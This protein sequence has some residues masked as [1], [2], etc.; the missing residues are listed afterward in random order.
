MEK[1]WAVLMVHKSRDAFLQA[2][3]GILGHLVHLEPALPVISPCRRCF[4]LDNLPAFFAAPPSQ[5]LLQPLR[6]DILDPLHLVGLFLLVCHL[7]IT[8]LVRPRE[9]DTG[10]DRLVVLC[11]RLLESVWQLSGGL[12]VP[13]LALLVPVLGVVA[14]HVGDGTLDE[15]ERRLCALSHLGAFVEKVEDHVGQLEETEMVGERQEQDG[16]GG[17]EGGGRGVE[18]GGDDGGWGAGAG[19]SGSGRERW[20]GEKGKFGFGAGDGDGSVGGGGLD[21]GVDDGGVS[22]SV[23]SVGSVLGLVKYAV[24][25]QRLLHLLLP[26]PLVHAA[27]PAPSQSFEVLLHTRPPDEHHAALNLA[28]LHF[29]RVEHAGE[30][31]RHRGRRE[32]ECLAALEEDGGVQLAGDGAVQRRRRQRVVDA[33]SDEVWLRGVQLSS[34]L[35]TTPLH[36]P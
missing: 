23:G 10:L 24:I 33:G 27:F 31:E 6:L 19:G 14:V 20:A 30:R 11:A 16:R 1:K 22:G 18:M 21:V 26:L 8:I 34:S 25:L 15:G 35:L 28:P 2:L 13:A 4:G 29:S 7:A 3:L 36:S 17:R 5:L 32:T 9:I 12:V